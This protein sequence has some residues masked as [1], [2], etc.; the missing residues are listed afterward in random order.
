MEN[1]FGALEKEFGG[2]RS[3]PVMQNLGRHEPG[4]ASRVV[5]MEIAHGPFLGN[6]WGTP[7]L[8]I[9][10]NSKKDQIKC[11]QFYCASMLLFFFFF[12]LL[13]LFLF[14]LLLSLSAYLRAYEV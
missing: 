1:W 5:Y 8:F 2:E 4:N 12:H 14:P 3:T 11:I 7:T 9:L 10:T 6:E 13:P